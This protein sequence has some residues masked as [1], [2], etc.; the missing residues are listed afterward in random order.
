M[1][2]NPFI[3]AVLPNSTAVE[4]SG[5]SGKLFRKC[6]AAIALISVVALGGGKI[7]GHWGWNFCTGMRWQRMKICCFLSSAVRF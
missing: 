6:M 5:I 2:F 4:I 1:Y 3:I 7:L